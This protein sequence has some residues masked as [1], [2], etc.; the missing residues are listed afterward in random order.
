MTEK[1]DKNNSAS[2]SGTQ[3]QKNSSTAKEEEKAS[4]VYCDA[5]RLS[6][7]KDDKSS[8]AYGERNSHSFYGSNYGKEK[9]IS[10]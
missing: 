6:T 5:R 4:S 9:G 1:K 7:N 10:S 3:N 2:R 8:T